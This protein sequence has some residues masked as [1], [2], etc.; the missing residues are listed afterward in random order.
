[1][2]LNSWDFTLVAFCTKAR[3]HLRLG[4]HLTQL[5]SSLMGLNIFTWRTIP[6]FQQGPQWWSE[7]VPQTSADDSGAVV[8]HMHVYR[9][10][11]IPS[12]DLRDTSR[13]S[14]CCHIRGE[15]PSMYV[16]LYLRLKPCLLMAWYDRSTTAQVSWQSSS[17][18]PRLD[19]DGRRWNGIM[20]GHVRA[21]CTRESELLS[22][23]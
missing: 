10:Q 23:I 11:W 14:R 22:Y 21:S 13:W 8:T 7:V 6:R 5:L 1:M 12:F 19:Y 15:A 2:E 16:L 4:L 20:G 17:C 18:T 9:S 3:I